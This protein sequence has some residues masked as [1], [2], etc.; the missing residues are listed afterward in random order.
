ME[1]IFHILYL[2]GLGSIVVFL[3]AV[4]MESERRR[5]G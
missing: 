2:F 4:T 3:A 5:E 1:I